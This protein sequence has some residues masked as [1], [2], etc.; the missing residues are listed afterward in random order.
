MSTENSSSA[1]GASEAKQDLPLITRPELIRGVDRFLNQLVGAPL[2]EP[3][4]NC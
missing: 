2:S 1:A 3:H 4:L